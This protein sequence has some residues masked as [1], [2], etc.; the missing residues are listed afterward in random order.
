MDTIMRGAVKK[1]SRLHNS[2]ISLNNL[3][4]NFNFHADLGPGFSTL[5]QTKKLPNFYKEKYRY[6][7]KAA[8]KK[9]PVV[10]EKDHL[11]PSS[12]FNPVTK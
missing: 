9:I 10:L 3:N 8:R 11:N 5:S 4:Q 6:L 7:L 1:I 12:F 2:S